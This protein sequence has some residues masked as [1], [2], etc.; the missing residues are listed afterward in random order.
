MTDTARTQPDGEPDAELFA[1]CVARLMA[2]ARCEDV[3]VLDLHGLS[4]VTDYFIIATGTSS[5]QLNSV[6]ADLKELARQQDQSIFRSDDARAQTGWAVVDFV[7]V[8]AH[9]MTAD[10]RAYYDLEG[11]W[12]DAPQVRW[13]Q[14]T[15]P[16]QF[17]R[18]RSAPGGAGEA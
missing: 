6:V 3:Q 5:R 16:G 17:A 11:L 7:D 1:C 12:G 10:Q 14:R 13:R 4:Q 2:D 8:V 15:T 18:L 9:L